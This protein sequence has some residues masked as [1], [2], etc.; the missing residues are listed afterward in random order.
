MGTRELYHLLPLQDEELK[1]IDILEPT[2]KKSGDWEKE[3]KLV[4]T[5]PN[6]ISNDEYDQLNEEFTAYTLWEPPTA[7]GIAK[8]DTPDTYW[9]KVSSHESN[10]KPC[11]PTLCKLAKAMLILP[12]SNAAVERAFRNLN[13]IKT[14]QISSLDS[15]MLNALMHISLRKTTVKF[16]P[17]NETRKKAR[18]LIT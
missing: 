5:F 9:N 15:P 11:F 4:K 2:K 10:G 1:S 17:T 16:Q 7:L 12:H 18:H 14:A 6:V 8:T 3:E 13:L